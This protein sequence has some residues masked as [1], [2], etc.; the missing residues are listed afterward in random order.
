MTR[1]GRARPDELGPNT[2][3]PKALQPMAP[4]FSRDLRRGFARVGSLALRQRSAAI[5]PEPRA[6]FDVWRFE[7]PSCPA[8]LQD[9]AKERLIEWYWRVHPRFNFFKSVVPSARVLD[10]G[11]GSGGL[12][13]C[14]QF[15][16]P[17][18]SDIPFFA[19]NLPG[20]PTPPPSHH[21]RVP[22]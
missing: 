14:R 2:R 22:P 16:D 6:S 7:V 3:E 5:H 20:P 21:F 1:L 19:I 4:P 13:F 15:L 18:P 17:D 12:P 10:V 11:A 9:V 8:G